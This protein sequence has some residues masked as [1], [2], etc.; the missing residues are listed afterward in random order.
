LFVE[1]SDQLDEPFAEILDELSNQYILGYESSNT[2]RN[3]SWRE[4][5]LEVPGTGYSVRSR[6]GYRAPGS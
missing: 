6:Q 3:G 2:Q 4:V 1:R 5:K